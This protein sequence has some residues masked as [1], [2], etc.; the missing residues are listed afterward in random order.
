[1]E[2]K[3][4]ENWRRRI[5]Q[6]EHLVEKVRLMEEVSRATPCVVS[7]C[8]TWNRKKSTL[9]VGLK[10]TSLRKVTTLGKKGN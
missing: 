5:L 8:H 9:S 2:P 10:G 3:G 4:N 1:M 7:S 6:Y